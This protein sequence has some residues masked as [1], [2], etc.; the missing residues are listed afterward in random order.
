MSRA[1]SSSTPS[2]LTTRP[3][4]S[5]NRA[6]SASPSKVMPKSY[7][8]F[9]A[10][11]ACATFSGCSAPQP[12][13]MLRPS[14]SMWMKSAAI[15]QSRNTSGA[16]DAGGAVGA[17]HQHAQPAE[18]GVANQVCQPLRILLPQLLLAR[19]HVGSRCRSVGSSL[20]Q[21][22]EVGKDV[23][24]DFVFQLVGELVAVGAEDLDAVVL[25][26]IVRG[27]D[28]D[29]G[30]E[31]IGARE[32]RHA[33]RGD[34]A[35]AHHL[36]LRGLQPGGQDRADP[37]A[38]FARVL[39]DDD[40]SGVFQRAASRCPSAR[41]MAY[42]VRRSSGYSPATPRIPSVPN[43]CRISPGADASQA[44]PPFP[45]VFFRGDRHM[46][47]P[48]RLH[49]HQRIGH[50]GMGGK[51]R[52]CRPTRLHP[53]DRSWRLAM[54]LTRLSGPTMVTVAG[55]VVTSVMPYPLNKVPI[56]RGCTATVGVALRSKLM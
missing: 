53:P 3:A 15:P 28:D 45:E 8:P 38:R 29:P 9:A 5:E 34:D 25:P 23:G 40:A 55:S 51:R 19:Q 35:G 1:A 17:I 43:S 33:R 46:N 42:T 27:R 14:G 50:V 22:L 39:P 31:T 2:P 16:I 56:T 10:A 49:A 6:R 13:L 37:G 20:R 21:L 4:A 44:G 12:A 52:L 11:T 48:G 18:I 30:G 32:V 24:L 26:G 47:R 36:H 54:A 41:P 7:L